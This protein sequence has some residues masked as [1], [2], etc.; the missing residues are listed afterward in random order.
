MTENVR[1]LHPGMGQAVGERTVLRYSLHQDELDQLGRTVQI[2][3][4]ESKD[5]YLKWNVASLNSG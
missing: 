5:V 1:D 4:K 3:P 2:N